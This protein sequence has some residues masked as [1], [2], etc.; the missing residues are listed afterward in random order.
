MTL[1]FSKVLG[2]TKYFEQA[3]SKDED[4]KAIAQMH[5]EAR[6][7]IEVSTGVAQ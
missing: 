6:S 7:Y 2:W 5:A 1:E 4:A 3:G